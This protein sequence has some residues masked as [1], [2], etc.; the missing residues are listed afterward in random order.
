[1]NVK[2]QIRLSQVSLL[3]YMGLV[4]PVLLEFVW[5]LEAVPP[6]LLVQM[7]SG[8]AGAAGAEVPHKFVRSKDD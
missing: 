1:M 4:P 6:V 3:G 5:A 2:D 8:T 7:G